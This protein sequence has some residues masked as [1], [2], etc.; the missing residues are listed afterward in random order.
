M[1]VHE[2]SK[3]NRMTRKSTDLTSGRVLA[4]QRETKQYVV[5]LATTTTLLP[6]FGTP[7]LFI[8]NGNGIVKVDLCTLSR[9]HYPYVMACEFMDAFPGKPFCIQIANR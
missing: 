9:Q 8:I 4:V 3:C 6:I 1:M 5:P 7:F 2:A